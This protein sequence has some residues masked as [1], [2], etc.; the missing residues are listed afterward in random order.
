MVDHRRGKKDEMKL[1]SS[2]QFSCGTI[3]TTVK[4]T[5]ERPL[6]NDVVDMLGMTIQTLINTTIIP[7]ATKLLDIFAKD[8]THVSR[9]IT[10]TAMGI[11]IKVTMTLTVMEVGVSNEL[12]DVLDDSLYQLRDIASY[13]W[14]E[15]QEEHQGSVLVMIGD[16]AENFLNS[17]FGQVVMSSLSSGSAGRHSNSPLDDLLGNLIKRQNPDGSGGQRSTS[18]LFGSLGSLADTFGFSD[19]FQR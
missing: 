13:A 12:K 7:K 2:Q 10:S 4:I 11:T 9:D 18:T 5:S 19:R 3:D 1:K 14:E 15:S 6:N 16:A 17:P 8:M